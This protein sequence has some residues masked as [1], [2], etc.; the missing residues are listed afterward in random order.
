MGACEEMII[1]F[2]RGKSINPKV[3]FLASDVLKCGVQ[4]L[5]GLVVVDDAKSY[6][7]QLDRDILFLN[8]LERESERA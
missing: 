6:R 7:F 1:A 8:H 3:Y 2:Y 5:I 4:S